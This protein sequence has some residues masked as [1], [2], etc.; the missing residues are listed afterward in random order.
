MKGDYLSALLKSE[1]TIFTYKDIALFWRE[2]ASPTTLVR[3]NYYIKKGEL[4][5][6]EKAFMPRINNTISWNLPLEY[7][8]LPRSVLKRS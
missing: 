1:K 4:K 8:R 5:N 7:S 2:E 6:Y 3:I